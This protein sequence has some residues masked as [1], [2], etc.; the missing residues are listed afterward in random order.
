[1]TTIA[2]KD[3]II[4][5]DSRM[6]SGDFIMSDEADKKIE[7]DDNVFFLSGATDEFQSFIDCYEG[8]SQPLWEL[9]VSAFVVSKKDKIAYCS[10]VD[11]IEKVGVIVYK[12]EIKFNRAIGSG[13]KL[14]FAA[15]DFGRTAKEAVEYAMTRD[16]GTGGKVYE[17]KI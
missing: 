15:M 13:W 6:T 3:G 1:M 10:G 17:Y 14:A 8:R 12:N 5:Y 7:T 11:Q 16:S 9:N 4:A 2:Y